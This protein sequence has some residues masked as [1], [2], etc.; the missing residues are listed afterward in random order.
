MELFFKESK[1]GG[2]SSLLYKFLLFYYLW[3]FYRIKLLFVKLSES[4]KESYLL[5]FINKDIYLILAD[6]SEGVKVFILLDTP[7]FGNC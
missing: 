3:Y 2:Q 1:L 6:I 7:L 4:I 5:S